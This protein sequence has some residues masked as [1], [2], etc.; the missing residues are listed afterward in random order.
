MNKS[1]LL[2]LLMLLTVCGLALLSTN[3]TH[4]WQT[5]ITEHSGYGGRAQAIAV[6]AKGDVIAAGRI[7]G[8]DVVKLSGKNGSEIWRYA[9]S[10][11][12]SPS[13][14]DDVAVDAAG[15]VYVVG[16]DSSRVLKLSGVTGAVIWNK[17]IHA[18]GNAFV[19]Y[20]KAVT[21]DREGNVIA[22]GEIGGNFTVA[23]LSGI[24]G[25]ELWHYQIGSEYHGWANDVAVD[26]DRNVVA[27]GT[28]NNNFFVVK[29]S[30][31]DGVELWHQ[32]M[33][34]L[35]PNG[36]VFEEAKAVAIDETGNAVAVG[37][38]RNENFGSFTADFTV[39]KF[40]GANGNVIWRQIVDG[41][42]NL[43]DDFCNP[44]GIGH[45]DDEAT[46]VGIDANGDVLAAGSVSHHYDRGDRC[47]NGWWGKQFDVRKFS[48]KSGAPIWGAV[49]DPPESPRGG[50]AHELSVDAAGNVVAVG[51]SDNRI[52]VV[53]F[54]G[55]SG[56]RAWLRDDMGGSGSLNWDVVTDTAGDV[57]AAG[58]RLDADGFPKF[59][60][61]KLR[62]ED[63]K[64]YNDPTPNPS[65]TPVIFI[66]GATGSVLRNLDD[67]SEL[68]PG[69][70]TFHNDLSLDPSS[71]DNYRP[72]VNPSDILRDV[73]ITVPP[74]P[75]YPAFYTKR[76]DIYKPLLD[77]FRGA[78]YVDN[79]SI[80]TLF[81]FPYDWRKS[82]AVNATL[83]R[84]KI[85]EIRQIYPNSKVNIVTHSMGGVL[86]RRYI[87]DNPSPD[88][89]HVDK[90]ITIAAPWLGAPKA[91]LAMETGKFLSIPIALNPTVKKLLEFFPGAHELLP[92][93]AYFDL[94]ELD[95]N[96]LKPFKEDGWNANGSN[97]SSEVYR[98]DQLY[99]FL[100]GAAGDYN[101]RLRRSEPYRANEMFHVTTGQDDW[102]GKGYGVDYYH[103]YGWQERSETIHQV[104][105]KS[106]VRCPR[107]HACRNVPIFET[108][109][110]PGDGTVPVLSA[111]RRGRGYD[112]NY[113]EGNARVK[114][115]VGA[116]TEH[117]KLTHNPDVQR[118]IISILN[119][120]PQSLVVKSNEEDNTNRLNQLDEPVTQQA[121]YL[122]VGGAASATLTDEAGNLTYPLGDVPNVGVPETTSYQLGQDTFLSIMPTDDSFTLTFVTG[123]SPIV[124][125]LTKGTHVETA[126]AI[127]YLDL[128]LPANT[129]VQLVITPEGVGELRYDSDGNGTF[130]STVPPTVSVSGNAAQDTQAP[131]IGV[132][133]VPLATTRRVT[134]AATDEG[135]GVR[136]VFYSL[137]GTNFQPYNGAF[138][139]N[140]TQTTTVYVFA[141]DNVAN[142]SSLV[143]YSVKKRR[144][145]RVRRGSRDGF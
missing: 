143:T 52:T 50:T 4:A 60:V 24:D 15:D 56:K 20:M 84:N 2:F 48:G 134:I 114:R 55:S 25:T 66:P 36:S 12:Y 51:S 141:E 35:Q 40:S 67:G 108:E 27:V 128:D 8:F 137:D 33:G 65:L 17:G 30:G 123:E 37:S 96:L 21:V 58:E 31:G 45:G 57:I 11:Y 23:K 70:G 127:R 53:K 62:R 19:N 87:L 82:N 77:A 125:N 18:R 34:S 26:D 91:I 47:R 81:L 79:G 49:P 78:G 99:N 54:L 9:P 6:D 142:R 44:R 136:A 101:A 61:I 102:R 112:Y 71:G 68:W 94:V 95:S 89:H 13:T 109:L 93:K 131:T 107:R 124:V 132:N 113:K 28:R 120:T 144:K 133:E 106:E 76:F 1:K 140:P 14:P 16:Y 43:I 72:H 64:G 138:V 115:F 122:R 5:T 85:I 145:G 121:Y 73:H 41:L 7:Y 97:G 74:T 69:L 110:G 139:I 104:V 92:S 83:L 39:V 116:N 38:T 105:A 98:Y 63:G 80:P 75:L 118:E 103:L 111:A 135:A 22:A 10:T 59:T 130:E 129:N 90:L 3:S 88:L 100:N 42:I 117:L 29:L 32:Q 126:Q 46:A 119:S 86:A